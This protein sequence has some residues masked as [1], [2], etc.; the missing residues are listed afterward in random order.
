MPR[1]RDDL[2]LLP[3]PDP[4]RDHD[5]FGP[6]VREPV[7][8]ELVRGPLHREAS[9]ERDGRDMA[10]DTKAAATWGRLRRAGA[11][12]A[13]KV[14]GTAKSSAYS[15]GIADPSTAPSQLNTYHKGQTA[16]TPP[17]K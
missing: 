4:V 5:L 1:R 10:T 12:S 8:P 14:I 2:G 17:K 13:M 3:A 15:G 11:T 6:D 9:P 7:L 16:I